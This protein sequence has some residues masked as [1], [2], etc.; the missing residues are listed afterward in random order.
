MWFWLNWAADFAFI[1]FENKIYF[2]FKIITW[3][4]RVF[5]K[6]TF[7]YVCFFHFRKSNYIIRLL[8]S[9]FLEFR[10]LQH[11]FSN[12]FW[13]ILAKYTLSDLAD[14]CALKTIFCR[15]IFAFWSFWNFGC[16]FHGSQNLKNGNFILNVCS[17]S[18]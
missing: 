4:V 18:I 5:V 3:D 7:S 17:W 6:R 13:F 10:K 8:I 11:E 16:W 12:Y 2:V 14:D 1:S 15:T 9:R